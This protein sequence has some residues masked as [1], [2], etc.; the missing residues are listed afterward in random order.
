VDTSGTATGAANPSKFGFGTLSPGEVEILCYID[1]RPLRSIPVGTNTLVKIKFSVD[2]G[3][4]SGAT[5]LDLKNVTGPPFMGNLL[6]YAGGNVYPTLVDGNFTV[7]FKC[8]DADGDGVVNVTDVVYLINY[9]FLVPPG[10]PPKPWAAGDVD[11][12]GVINVS[13]VVYLINFLY[14]IPPGPPPCGS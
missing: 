7:R 6:D 13:D 5:L 12:N 4:P 8:G 11:C 10:L 9:K 2:E 14:L 3:A 1:C